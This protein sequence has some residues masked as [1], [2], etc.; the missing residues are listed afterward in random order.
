MNKQEA[1]FTNSNQDFTEMLKYIF[2][3]MIQDL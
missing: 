1:H 3:F 2:F